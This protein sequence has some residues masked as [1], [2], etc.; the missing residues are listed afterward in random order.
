MLFEA[1]GE[2][3]TKDKQLLGS[4]PPVNTHPQLH[5]DDHSRQTAAKMMAH[6][7]LALMLMPVILLAPSTKAADLSTPPTSTSTERSLSPPPRSWRSTSPPESTLRSRPKQLSRSVEP[8]NPTRLSRTHSGETCPEQSKEEFL[9]YS[10]ILPQRWYDL[11]KGEGHATYCVEIQASRPAFT[12]S[13][14]G[15]KH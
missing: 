2:N 1:R 5:A 8:A 10:E 9:F 4:A 12:R 14:Q 3:K 6:M 13:K 7:R 11:R 15:S